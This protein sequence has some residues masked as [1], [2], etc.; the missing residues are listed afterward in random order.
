[1]SRDLLA[2]LLALRP[3]DMPPELLLDRPAW[4]EQAACRGVGPDVFFVDKGQSTAPAKALC[5]QCTVRQ[6]CGEAGLYEDHGIWAGMV[7]R[8]RRAMRRAAA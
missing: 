7:P 3:L 6:A 2:A 5:D 1:M 8:A 4:H